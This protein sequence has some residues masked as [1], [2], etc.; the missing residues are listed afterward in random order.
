M[1]HNVKFTMKCDFFFLKKLRL[2]RINLYIIPKKNQS[3]YI[4]IY[5]S[6][7]NFLSTNVYN[8]L[9][10]FTFK[11]LIYFELIITLKN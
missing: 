8:L 5:K 6:S 9:Q 2:A 10:Y 4:Y 11:D 7:F 1:D 3:V